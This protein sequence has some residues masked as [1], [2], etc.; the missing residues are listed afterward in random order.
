MQDLTTPNYLRLQYLFFRLTV[1]SENRFSWRQC[2]IESDRFSVAA[3]RS[4]LR[5][6][7]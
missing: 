6:L 2:N 4:K 3:A 7:R 1:V 5:D